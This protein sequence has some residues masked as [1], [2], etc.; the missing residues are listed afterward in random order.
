MEFSLFDTLRP[1]A[2]AGNISWRAHLGG[3]IGGM[4]SQIRSLPI[5]LEL[6]YKAGKVT[7]EEFIVIANRIHEDEED[8]VLA[9]NFH[10]AVNDFQESG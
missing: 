5:A 3:V 4:A 7:K 6:L 10:K 1:S 8:E 9:K 2:E